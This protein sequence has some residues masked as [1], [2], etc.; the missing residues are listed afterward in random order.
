MQSDLLKDLNLEQQKAVQQTD[1]PI[2]VLAGAG[3]GKTRV[4][5]YKVMYLIMEK[6]ISPDR[7]LMV[8][9]TNKA[10]NEMK[11]RIQKF[12]SDLDFR[13]TQSV[14]PLVATFH[15][16]CAKL[17]RREGRHIGLSPGFTIFDSQ[18]Q[19]DAIKEAMGKLYISVKDYKPAAIH[20][21]ISQAKKR[22]YWTRTIHH[23][24]SRTISADC[25]E[26]LSLL[27]STLKRE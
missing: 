12:S 9:F 2:I 24:C 10:A 3:S 19:I 14:Q 23:I 8:T 20:A 11:E 27:P 13:Y 17:L 4:L 21:T 5:T 7:I 16:L 6:H 15:S 22:T 1:G 26:D 25:S 18:D